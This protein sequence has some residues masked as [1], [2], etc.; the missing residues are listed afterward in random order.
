M[1]AY[2]NSYCTTLHDRYRPFACLFISS[3]PPTTFTPTNLGATEVALVAIAAAN[4]VKEKLFV[5]CIVYFNWS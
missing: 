4:S 3:H 1:N 5:F 2:H